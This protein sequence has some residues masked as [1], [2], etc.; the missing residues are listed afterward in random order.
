MAFI[1]QRKSLCIISLLLVISSLTYL[2]HL[3]TT[4]SQ[5]RT[6][7]V[8]TDYLT[9]EQT[10][11][12][13]NTTFDC[14]CSHIQDKPPLG[15]ELT[16]T[17][18]I[19]IPDTLPPPPSSLLKKIHA[20]LLED[21]VLIVATANYG[22]RQYVYNWIES[23]K[24]TK[25]R[26][27]LI[28]CF[29][30]Q[31]YDHLTKAGYGQHASMIPDIW[32]H[33]QV[34]ADFKTYFSKEYRV[35]T[36]SKTLVVQQLLYLDITVLFSDVDIVWLRPHIVDYVHGLM[37]LRQETHVLFQQEGM[38][39]QE[40][41]SGFYLM[42][43]TLDMKRLLAQTILIQDQNDGK[44]Q[45]GAMNIALDQLD[46]DLRTSSVVLL[47]VLHFPNG[48]VYF[49]HDLPRQHGIQPFIVHANYLVKVHLDLVLF[50]L[51]YILIGGGRKETKTYRKSLL[52]CE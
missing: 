16:P 14:D 51:M 19:D 29:D 49:T 50:S 2:T 41:N 40:V 18:T 31:L 38:N 37:K 12:D 20:N 45:Q 5:L 34:E 6:V 48:F 32:F 47:D 24:R 8:E 15:I 33:Q 3:Y 52:V 7:P 1:D 30:Q 44:T 17:E 9:N 10:F 39:Q 4:E 42:R 23:L 46:L 36:H 22:M 13:T 21:R 43:P 11:F 27:F 26:K 35:I 25:H 28:F